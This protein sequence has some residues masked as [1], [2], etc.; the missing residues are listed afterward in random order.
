MPPHIA[1]PEHAVLNLWTVGRSAH[2]VTREQLAALRDAHRHL[3]RRDGD[4]G[5][6]AADRLD[7]AQTRK[8]HVESANDTKLGMAILSHSLACLIPCAMLPSSE[9][10]DKANVRAHSLC[11]HDTSTA[12]LLRA[13][14]ISHAL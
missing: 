1:V 4:Q 7:T 14:T 6:V 5:A 8:Q 11:H 12:P 13:H 2:G 9:P 10:H 3:D